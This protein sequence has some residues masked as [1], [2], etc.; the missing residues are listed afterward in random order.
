MAMIKILQYPDPHLRIKTK[1]VT[2]VKD[3]RLQKIIDDMLETL[4]KTENCA[5]LA[6]TQLDI[7]EPVP[8]ITVIDVSD[9]KNQPLVLINP[10]IIAT[11]GEH[12]EMEGCMSVYPDEIH[13]IVTRGAKVKVKA[14]DRNGKAFEI[15]GTGIMAKCLQHEID[16]LD[17][18]VYIYRLSA[19]KRERI[20]KKIKKFN[21]H[22]HDEHCGCE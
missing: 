2:D 14:L 21:L 20:E 4:Y 6:A 1:P 18:I 17:G 7:P 15:E 22:N 16:H 5:G 8:R 10:E 13:G 9:R 3:P 11:E 12:S 19:L